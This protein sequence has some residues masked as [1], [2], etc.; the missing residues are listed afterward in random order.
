MNSILITG[1]RVIDPAHGLDALADVLILE[2]KGDGVGTGAGAEA[3]K[4]ARL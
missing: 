1:G 4:V 2:G 3:S